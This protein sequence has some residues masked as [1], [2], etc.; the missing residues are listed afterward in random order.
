MNS[1][2]QARQ[3]LKSIGIPVT[4]F[5]RKI[6]ISPTAFYRW[7]AN[8]LRLSDEKENK[9]KETISRLREATK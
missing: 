8:D 2:E 5:C 3:T 9:I 6:G 4:V 7:T 1:K